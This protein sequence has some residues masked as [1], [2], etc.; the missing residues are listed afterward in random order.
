M[1][2]RVIYKYGPIAPLKPI[3]VSGRVVH[4][5]WQNGEILGIQNGVYIWSEVDPDDLGDSYKVEMYPTGLIYSGEYLGTV[6]EPNGM[7]WHLVKI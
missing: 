3:E 5:S 1:S 7:V 6:V 4:V 2:K